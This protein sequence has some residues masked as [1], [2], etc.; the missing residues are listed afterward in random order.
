MCPDARRSCSHRTFVHWFAGFE[1]PNL[2]RRP[3]RAMPSHERFAYWLD[4]EVDVAWH[5]FSMGPQARV[6]LPGW[7]PDL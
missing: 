3:V 4:H 6:D 2:Q 7:I 5:T 1:H